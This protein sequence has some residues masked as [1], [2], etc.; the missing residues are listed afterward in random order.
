MNAAV[1]LVTGTRKFNHG[2][3]LLLHEELH[4]LNVPERMQYKLG[5]T[6]HRCLQY[7]VP[8]YLSTAVVSDIPSRHHLWS[9]TR[10]HLTVP[11]YWLSTFSRQAFLV[12]GPTVWNLLP[13]SLHDLALTASDNRW[14]RILFRSYH[15]AHTAQWRCFM[16]AIII[17]YWHWHWHWSVRRVDVL[18]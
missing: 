15:S 3:S 11:R 16:S 14:I 9:A 17:Y 2:L 1:R 5:V 4:W 8:E 7:N 12:A 18:S 10:Y 13:D 6:V